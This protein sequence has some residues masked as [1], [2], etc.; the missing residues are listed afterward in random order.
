MGEDDGRRGNAEMR[1]EA[2][3]R[4]NLPTEYC[5]RYTPPR[6]ESVLPLVHAQIRIVEGWTCSRVMSDDVG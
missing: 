6:R 2:Q 4:G 3:Q 1:E 5:C